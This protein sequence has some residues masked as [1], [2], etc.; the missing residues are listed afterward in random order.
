MFINKQE[1]LLARVLFQHKIRHSCSRKDQM[2]FFRSIRL[3]YQPL[4]TIIALEKLW[5]TGPENELCLQSSLIFFI[6]F[7]FFNIKFL[8]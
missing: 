8:K 6:L 7:Y 3:Q 2:T 1:Y 4:L 5:G